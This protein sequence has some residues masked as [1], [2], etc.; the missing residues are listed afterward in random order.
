MKKNFGI[1]FVVFV[2]WTNGAS[3]TLSSDHRA[4]SCKSSEIVSMQQ[5][6]KSLVIIGAGLS[7]LVCAKKIL[8]LWNRQGSGN[9]SVK[10]VDARDRVGGRLLASSSGIDLGAAWSWPEHDVELQAL[11]SELGVKL[12]QQFSEGMALSQASD[13]RIGKVGQNIGPSGPGSTR[14]KG[15]AAIIATELQNFL[16]SRNS[17]SGTLTFRLNTH[18]SRIEVQEN[19]DQPILVEGKQTSPTGTVPYSDRADAV[20]LALPPKLIAAAITFSPPLRPDKRD[21]MAATPTWMANTGKAVFV[22]PDRFWAA[23]GLSGTAFSDRGPLRQVWDSSAPPGLYA[24]AGFVFDDDL[25]HLASEQAARA[26]LLPQLAA[27]FGPRAA[28]PARVEVKSWRHDPMTGRPEPG[29]AARGGAL[30]FGHPLVREPHGGGRVVFAG[31]ET[32]PGEN[33]HLNGAV[34]AGMRAAGEALRALSQ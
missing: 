10:I 2:V 29:G 25:E 6:S 18:I 17:G 32:A 19:A 15:G 28:E 13:G 14:F 11:A 5:Q 31:T 7:G 22:Y 9:L 27:L 33:G 16:Q 20:V 24:L 30:Q 4:E 34:I 21:A 12:E 23:A 3:T 8:E 1:C 26:A